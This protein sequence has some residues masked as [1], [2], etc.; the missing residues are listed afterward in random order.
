MHSLLSTTTSLLVGLALSA[1]IA[2]AAYRRG[3]LDRSGLY[4]ATFVGA[5]VLGLGG[6]TAGAA[7]LVFFVTGSALS[8]HR[9][10]EKERIVGDQVEKGGRRDVAQVLANGGVAAL[11]SLLFVV[12]GDEAL[13]GAAVG[14]LAAAA[15]DTWATEIGVLLGGRPRML[16]T[17][18]PVAPGTS[19]AVS[20][21]GLAGMAAG[22]ALLAVVAA[23]GLGLRAAAPVFCAGV[24]GSMADSLL[25]ATVQERRA[26]TG[27]GQETEQRRHLCGAATAVC[28]GIAGVDNDVVNALCTALGAAV[29]WLLW[30]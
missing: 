25:G 3:S 28:G 11:C 29:A 23:L 24:L 22:A 16:L 12:R 20:L 6:G 17:L 15:A 27:C 13:R 18:R 5:L 26:C 9:A 10:E 14:S 7:L 8:H 4:A 21:P 2:W 19:G 1:A 30:P